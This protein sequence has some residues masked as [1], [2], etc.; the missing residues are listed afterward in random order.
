VKQNGHA[1]QY[2]K[3]QSPEICSVAMSNNSNVSVFIQQ[4]LVKLTPMK[5]GPK[6][7]P[8]NVVNGW[9]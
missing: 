2:V 1:L 9:D 6:E 7:E 8:D 4:T 3:E 5:M